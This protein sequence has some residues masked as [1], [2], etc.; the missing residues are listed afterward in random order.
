MPYVSRKTPEKQWFGYVRP[1]VDRTGQRIGSLTIKRYGGVSNSNRMWMCVCDCGKEKLV[2]W[3]NLSRKHTTSCGCLALVG[4]VHGGGKKNWGEARFNDL[5]L[6]YQRRAV[7]RKISFTL[8][9][10]EFRTLTRSD[11]YYCGQPPSQIVKAGLG[12]HGEYIYSGIDRVDNSLGYTLVNS[13]P[14]CK[15]CNIAKST[16]TEEQFFNNILRAGRV[17]SKL[18]RR[19]RST[20][21]DFPLLDGLNYEPFNLSDR[22]MEESW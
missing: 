7:K 17:I 2:S 15:F 16:L 20:T 6:S 1:F 21:P 19:S 3:K 13:R 22:E 10:D 18:V 5:F 8:T 14:C 4:L 12:V 11:C 9:K